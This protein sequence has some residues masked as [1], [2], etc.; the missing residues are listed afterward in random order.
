MTV[1]DKIRNARLALDMTQED[2]GNAVGVQ[3]SAIAKYENGRVVN[4]KR[5]TIQKLAEVLHIRPSDLVYDVA[6]VKTEKSLDIRA[7]PK[8]VQEIV[9][10]CL[11]I[12]GLAGDLKM[13]AQTIINR[14]NDK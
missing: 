12:P 3:K 5:S 11:E 7:L 14:R 10:L 9:N 6:E 4:I 2:L 13:I 1:G 8:D